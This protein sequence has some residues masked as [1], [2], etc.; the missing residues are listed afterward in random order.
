MICGKEHTQNLKGECGMKRTLLLAALAALLLM[1]VGVAQ[2][3]TSGVFGNLV[4]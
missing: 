4:R 2:A 3:E 1:L